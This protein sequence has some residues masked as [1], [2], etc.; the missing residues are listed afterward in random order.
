MLEL[1]RSWKSELTAEQPASDTDSPNSLTRAAEL[2]VVENAGSESRGAPGLHGSEHDS[3]SPS[4]AEPEN[5]SVGMEL[6]DSPFE[7]ESESNHNRLPD[8]PRASP[9]H[10]PVGEMTPPPSGRNSGERRSSLGSAMPTPSW[11][12]TPS[13]RGSHPSSPLTPQSPRSPRV[14]LTPEQQ[15]RQ[16]LQLRQAEIELELSPTGKEVSLVKPLE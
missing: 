1:C 5:P 4:K 14:E 10:A 8:S 16:T 9:L 2:F 6:P 3:L 12:P 7:L 15:Q 11:S 13:S